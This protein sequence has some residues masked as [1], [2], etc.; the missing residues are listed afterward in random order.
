MPH[1]TLLALA[2]LLWRAWP[3][4]HW[5]DWAIAALFLREWICN[6][7]DAT[8]GITRISWWASW[9]AVFGQVALALPWT[10]G[11]RIPLFVTHGPLRAGSFSQ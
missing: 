7:A 5:T 1:W 11:Q 4:W 6:A 9:A 10:G 3:A 2:A 8:W